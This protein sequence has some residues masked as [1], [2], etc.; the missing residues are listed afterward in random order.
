[1]GSRR[2]VGEAARGGLAGVLRRGGDLRIPPDFAA[3]AEWILLAAR[4]RGSFRWLAKTPADWRQ[5]GRDWPQTRYEAKAIAAGRRC[6]YFRFL[7][8][9]GPAA[10]V[11]LRQ[12]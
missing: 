4:R 7:N 6:S 5:R 2:S 8:Q 12:N 9:S 11:G 1:H 3:Y 10:A